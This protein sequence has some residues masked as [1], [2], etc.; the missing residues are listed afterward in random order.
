MIANM[1][2]NPTNNGGDLIITCSTI[3]EDLDAPQNKQKAEA[4]DEVRNARKA[5]PEIKKIRKEELQR[6]FVKMPK[7]KFKP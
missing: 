1:K 4:E 5:T 2:L 7:K 3:E 6:I